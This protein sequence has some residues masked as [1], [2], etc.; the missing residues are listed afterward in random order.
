MSSVMVN[1]EDIKTAIINYLSSTDVAVEQPDIR[2]I[3]KA[4]LQPYD[5]IM[6]KKSTQKKI[7]K[8]LIDEL[9]NENIIQIE[10][11]TASN[12]DEN[13]TETKEVIC[14]IRKSDK[15][16]RKKQ[17]I[18]DENFI[19]VNESPVTITAT[20]TIENQKDTAVIVEEPTN[21]SKKIKY[22]FNSTNN[23]HELSKP[24]DGPTTILLFYAYSNP[25][26]SRGEQDNAISFCYGKLQELGVTGRLRVARE[27]FNSTLTGSRDGIRQFTA[28]LRKYS[29]ATFS[30]TDFKY[31]D[32][33]PLN[34]MLKGLKVWPVTEIVTY[35][36]DPAQA[37]LDKRG[38]H[39]TPHEFHEKLTDE[40]TIV[41][42]V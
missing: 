41:I 25:P 34:Q 19:E 40:N 13:G 30:N 20:T 6:A 24:E 10:T 14:L 15:K 12:E 21:K 29:P 42:D 38:V 35:G 2:K 36:F 27:G 28:A 3:R 8:E 31:V 9:A 18:I 7:I 33:L 11:I 37:P 1:K 22:D 16:K 17:K 26:M 23:N 5:K 39:L 32:G 4:V